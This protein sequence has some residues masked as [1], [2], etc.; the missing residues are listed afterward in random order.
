MTETVGITEID[1]S[2]PHMLSIPEAQRE[3]RTAPVLPRTATWDAVLSVLKASLVMEE[4]SLPPSNEF[5][6]G[7]SRIR[8]SIC[9]ANL[10]GT[11]DADGTDRGLAQVVVDAFRSFRRNHESRFY[12]HWRDGS[13]ESLW[14]DPYFRKEI[15]R[16]LAAEEVDIL[17]IP[18]SVSD[19][20]L[21]STRVPE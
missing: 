1:A 2:D 13:I 3:P 15:G 12:S 5:P 18:E 14:S 17:S 11:L 6:S 16:S 19:D 4:A 7:S 10:A 9:L 20:D 8:D 21:A